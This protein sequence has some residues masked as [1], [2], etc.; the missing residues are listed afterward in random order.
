MMI[1]IIM[2]LPRATSRREAEKADD[3]VHGWG[4]SG[5]FTPVKSLMA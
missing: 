5:V 3:G 1:T 4:V 2:T